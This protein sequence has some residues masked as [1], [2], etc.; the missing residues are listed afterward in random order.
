MRLSRDVNVREISCRGVTDRDLVCHVFAG[1]GI[2]TCEIAGRDINGHGV[3]THNVAG[4]GVAGR[5]IDVRA[6]V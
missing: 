6:F 2:R 4:C 1:R 3:A 5:D